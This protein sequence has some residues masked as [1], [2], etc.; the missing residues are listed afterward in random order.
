M[1]FPH[2]L[3]A[4]CA[5]SGRAIL[6]HIPRVTVI[7]MDGLD[8]VVELVPV[9]SDRVLSPLRITS[10]NPEPGHPGVMRVTFDNTPDPMLWNSHVP[11]ALVKTM[12]AERERRLAGA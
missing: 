12:A 11:P 9:N 7:S 8:P 2:G 10:Y 3:L 4:S 5:K 6:Y 1:Q